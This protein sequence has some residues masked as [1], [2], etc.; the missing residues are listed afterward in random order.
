MEEKQNVAC[1]V[2]S[3]CCYNIIKLAIVLRPIS[4]IKNTRDLLPTLLTNE[5][6]F[7]KYQTSPPTNANSKDYLY[8]TIKMSWVLVC[9]C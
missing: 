6:R 1:T 8:H 5:I 7:S 9:S 3:N 4:D 2:I